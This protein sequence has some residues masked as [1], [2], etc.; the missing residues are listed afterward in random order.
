MA[1]YRSVR[2]RYSRPTTPPTAPLITTLSSTRVPPSGSAAHSW[3][4]HRAAW[5][6]LLPDEGAAGFERG[7]R[8]R[9]GRDPRLGDLDSRPDG[10]GPGVQRPD[11][12]HGVRPLRP[13]LDVDEHVPHPVRRGRH[14]N[15]G[16]LLHAVHRRRDARSR[17]QSP[18]PQVSSRESSVSWSRSP[19]WVTSSTASATCCTGRTPSS[20][21][22]SP[23]SARLC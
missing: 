12:A 18:K 20:S 23:S 19:A 14:I 13:P 10:E 5:L 17:C 16:A 7:H 11:A 3:R 15:A 21:P 1:R 22:R 8:V 4:R 2:F 9:A 6:P